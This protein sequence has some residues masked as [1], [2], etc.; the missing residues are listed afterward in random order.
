MKPGMKVC[1]SEI[2]KPPTLSFTINSDTG[3][4]GI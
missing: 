1:T 3:G 2:R 4:G